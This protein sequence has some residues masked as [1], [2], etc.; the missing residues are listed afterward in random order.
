MDDDTPKP[1][2]RAVPSQ[3]TEEHDAP[4]I[5]EYGDDVGQP[6]PP[7]RAAM[8]QPTIGQAP[9]EHV[10]E[11]IGL[12]QMPVPATAGTIPG[13]G[14]HLIAVGGSASM[15]ALV[16]YAA[17]RDARGAII[18]TGVNLGLLGLVTAAFGGE[19]LPV[20]LRVVYGVVG[21]GATVGAG[22]LSWTRR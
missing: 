1:H 5:I 12:G 2:L 13:L 7:I 11:V 8:G 6:E 14:T 15:G 3:P 9:T 16:G 18:G 20:W 10:A 21:V 19:R 4:S 17:S 22:Y